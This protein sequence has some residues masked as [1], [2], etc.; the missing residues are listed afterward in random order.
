[1]A[2]RSVAAKDRYGALRHRL[3]A[4]HTVTSLRTGS[5]ADIARLARRSKSTRR[6]YR[7]FHMVDILPF[8]FLPSGSIRTRTSSC[9]LTQFQSAQS[10]I[11]LGLSTTGLL[12]S[13]IW[14]NPSKPPHATYGYI[15]RRGSPRE[16][17]ERLGRAYSHGTPHVFMTLYPFSSFDMCKRPKASIGIS[18]VEGRLSFPWQVLYSLVTASQG[19]NLSAQQRTAARGIMCLWDDSLYTGI[20]QW[21]AQ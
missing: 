6:T 2:R 9:A 4:L 5:H 8:Y 17:T 3:L 16:L 18:I 7:A 13:C 11:R 1:M 14:W 21:Y 20:R 19:A 10:C 15:K 12:T